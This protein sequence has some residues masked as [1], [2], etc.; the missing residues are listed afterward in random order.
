MIV[1][2]KRVFW[3]V[4]ILATMAVGYWFNT[5]NTQDVNLT[6]FGFVLP[7]SSLGV[8]VCLTLLL[9]G[10]LG[11]FASLTPILRLT[12]ENLS[13]KRKLKRRDAELTKLRT[14]ALKD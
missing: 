8:I 2:L 9:G 1:W 12:N 7:A 3:V 11:F 5:E 13:L 14:A 6:L 10:V 4:L